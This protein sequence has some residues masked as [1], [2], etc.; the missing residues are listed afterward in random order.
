VNTS[1]AFQ[2][3]RDDAGLTPEVLTHLV[4]NH[5]RFLDFLQ[6]RVGARD[7][8][9][10][11]LQEAFA[12]S[13]DRGST[14]REGESA[15]A[16]FYRLLRNA[17]TDHW[18]RKDARNRALQRVAQEPHE[19]EPAPDAELL[20]V[21]CT[22]VGELVDDLKPEYAGVLRKVELEGATVH[23]YADA[24]GITANNASVRLHRAREALR[25][26]LVRCCGTCATHGCLDCTCHP[27]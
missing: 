2:T 23:D 27:K 22:C 21:V 16:W 10:E 19:P 9:E 3:P 14:L 1:P 25:L 11:I 4:A 8:A 26:R 7:V 20:A 15:T 12:R 24:Q 6:R 18:R 13:I 5:Q 17:L